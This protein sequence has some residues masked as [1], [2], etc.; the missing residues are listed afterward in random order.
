MFVNI[1]NNI[2]N[3][4]NTKVFKRQQANFYFQQHLQILPKSEVWSF[5]SCGAFCYV[6][7]AYINLDWKLTWRSKDEKICVTEVMTIW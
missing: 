1:I 6:E 3:E 4:E 5:S 7:L 2:I